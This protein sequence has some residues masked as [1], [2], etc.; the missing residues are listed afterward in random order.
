[1]YQFENVGAALCRDGWGP[2]AKHRGVKPLLHP[3][4]GKLI[5]YL[6]VARVCLWPAR[7][8][9]CR[10]VKSFTS[11]RPYWWQWPTVL[12]LDAPAVA[13]LWQ[14]LLARVAGVALGWPQA[15]VLGSSV[16]LAYAADRWIEGWRLGPG[17][18]RTQRH[19]FYQRGRWPVAAGWLL[20]LTTDLAIATSR[21]SH[22]EIQAGLLLL[23]P[24]LAYLLSHQLIHRHHRW[25]APKEVCVA[26]LLASGTVL[27]IA[28]RP[29]A[30]LRPLAAPLALFALLCFA[31]C[32][33]ISVWEREVDQ[34]HGQTSFTLQFRRGA[35]FSRRL[36]WALAA[37]AVL[38][39]AAESGAARAAAACALT[40]SLL[41]A[42]VDRAEPRLGWQ[43]ARVLA[44]VALM[45]PLAPLLVLKLR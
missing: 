38:L 31:N 3:I 37:V 11:G 43:L 36:P 42:A 7:P 35:A 27:F 32:A 19:A 13:L 26:A 45:T 1:M 24:V 5:H 17:Q 21:L 34:T 20:V 29:D 22:R 33:L 40:S 10:I 2:P 16:W 41:L 12:S 8:F 14:G 39:V 18:V 23:A 9:G 30:A 44:D 25:R 6:N 4:R 28:A 15:L